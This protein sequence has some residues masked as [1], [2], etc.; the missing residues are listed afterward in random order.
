ME[1]ENVCSVHRFEQGI[2]LDQGVP[3]YEFIPTGIT[4]IGGLELEI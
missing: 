2:L 1:M 4:P 3:N